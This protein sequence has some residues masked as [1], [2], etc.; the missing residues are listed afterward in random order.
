MERYRVSLQSVEWY[1]HLVEMFTVQKSVDRQS[2]RAW[3]LHIKR[4]TSREHKCLSADEYGKSMYI[5]AGL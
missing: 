2:G 5:V 1:V 3:Y 4:I